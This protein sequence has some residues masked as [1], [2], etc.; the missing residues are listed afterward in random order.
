M[1]SLNTPNQLSRRNWLRDA[2]IAATSAA[3]L[4][5][6]LTS[7]TDHRIPPGVGPGGQLLTDDELSSAAQNLINFRKWLVELQDKN[8]DYIFIVY[9]TL[10]GGQEA[11]AHFSDI[12]L[13]TFITIGEKILGV[14]TAEIPGAGAA[15]AF[16]A[17]QIR[18]WV[19]EQKK[20]KGIDATIA[21]FANS[22][23]ELNIKVNDNLLDMASS[24]D[25]Y[26]NLQKAFEKGP[27]ELNGQK[28]TLQ[29]LAGSHFPDRSN[30]N[31]THNYKILWDAAY[32]KFRKYIWNSVLVKTAKMYASFGFNIENSWTPAKYARDIHY[33]DYPAT[34]LR[35]RFE[36][37]GDRKYLMVYYYFEVDGRELSTDAAKI[38]F[39]DDY[40]GHII[41]EEG[42]F[43]RDYV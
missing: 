6:L 18:A 25:N 16:G 19:A 20:G 2:A 3:V 1:K 28:Y 26:A 37:D 34:Y 42:L 36:S 8:F 15:L 9:T 39:K 38:L 22:Y 4:P 30:A 14:A 27:V 43:N 35:G 33:P 12:L 5:S 31:D 40:P 23:Q 21:N 10:K 11:P 32:L 13:D 41:N 7:C 17:E 29:D 24:N